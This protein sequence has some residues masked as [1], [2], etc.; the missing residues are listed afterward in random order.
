MPVR[1][2]RR[3]EYR[4][5]PVRELLTQ[6]KNLSSIALDLAYYS[7][8][9]ND[10]RVAYE[11]LKLED[12]I[13]DLWAL[14]VMQTSLAVSNPKEAER[15][16]SIYRV[17]N[18]LDKVSDAAGDIAAVVTSGRRVPRVLRHSLLYS[19]EAVFAV[20]ASRVPEGGIALSEIAKRVPSVDVVLL[21][22]SDGWHLPPGSSEVVRKG[23]IIVVRGLI[24]S[25]AELAAELGDEEA[26]STL[27]GVSASASEAGELVHLKNL[28]DIALDMAFHAVVYQDGSVAVEVLELEEFADSK[29]DAL[30]RKVVEMRSESPAE[31]LAIVRV[32]TSLEQITDAAAEMAAVVAT[33]LPAHEIL[34]SAEEE[35]REVVIKAVVTAAAEG[36]TLSEI[37]VEGLGAFVVAVKK[38]S[39]WLPM[40][41]GATTLKAGDVVI[42]K[43]YAP[44][45][46]VEGKLQELGLAVSE[47]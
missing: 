7:V 21:R 15:A 46:P 9:Y 42:L 28:A 6:I 39:Q 43:L 16:V 4:P 41:S 32:I 25:I 33:G 45:E 29:A 23:D 44:S 37:G 47:E 10:R 36:K 27:R 8:L 31:A 14:A 17:I 20:R 5:V 11:V 34:E 18:A 12:Y 35:S 40:P 1:V 2:P 24:D 26:Y 38:G 3:V 13:D 22:R 19:K 30:V